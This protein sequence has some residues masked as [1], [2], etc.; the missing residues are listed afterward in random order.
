MPSPIL[1]PINLKMDLYQEYPQL[2]QCDFSWLNPLFNIVV[3]VG[4][5]GNGVHLG[6][7]VAI[8]AVLMALLGI[9]W[10]LTAFIAFA[11]L[12]LKKLG[13]C[14]KECAQETQ[15]KCEASSFVETPE[16]VQDLENV[17]VPTVYHIEFREAKK[18]LGH[19]YV[20]R[21]A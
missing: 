19:G 15:R 16:E 2:S 17:S 8:L 1:A 11:T 20:P 18:P 7:T 14:I 5:Y 13:D 21:E 12:G 3:T 4:G 6:G 10:G 9:I